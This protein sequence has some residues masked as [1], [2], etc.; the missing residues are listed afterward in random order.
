ME[1]IKALVDSGH[2]PLDEAK[3]IVHHSFTWR[4][5]REQDERFHADLERNLNRD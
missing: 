1:S 5:K 2:V 4:D 3:R